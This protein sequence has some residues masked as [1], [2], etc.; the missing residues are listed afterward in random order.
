[1]VIALTH[2]CRTWRE[3]FTSRSSLWTEFHCVDSDK[4]RVYSE[5]SKSSPIT[6]WLDRD[7]GLLPQDPFLQIAPD[8]ISRLKSLFVS[9]TPDHLQA[10][11]NYFSR[12]A[13]LLENLEIFGSSDDPFL[14]PVL[15]TTLFDGDLSSLR[16][17]CLYSLHTT[18]PWRN[19]VNLT[20][21]ELG[22]VM[23]PRVTVGQLLDFFESAPSLVD[24]DLTFSTP[25]LGA[26]SGRLVPLAHLRKLSFNGFQPSSL[27]LEHLLIP[28]GVKMT[29]DLDL[30]GP[31]IE[32]Y[33]PRS[34]DNLRNL[35]NFKRIR[36]HFGFHFT[37]ME[38]IGPNGLV[39][40]DSMSPGADTPR[41][42][43]RSL[44]TLDTS[45]T[46]RLEIL[47]SE[48]L[49]EDLH[50]VL[51]S[52]KNLR[53]V[54]LSLCKDLRSFILA[55]APVPNSTTQIACPRLEELVFR[56]EERFDVETMVEVAAARA[57][58]GSPLKSIRIINWGELVSREEVTELLKHISH[59]E[60]SFEA[61]NVNYGYGKRSD[62]A[63][64]HGDD[65]DEEG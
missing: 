45:K 1:M 35:S 49:S 18:L 27:L 36:V 7:D 40:I 13:P 8:S 4:T 17:L 11:T 56:T 43:A 37:S 55:L 6:L 5:R 16:G 28:A 10:I 58:G 12:P 60:T 9:T 31:R 21:F 30:D 50:Q 57:S 53:T 2:V 65:S 14:N 39:E 46:K 38:F 61:R 52:M 34:L 24:V 25:A 41:S 54:T 26:Q 44:A 48:P 20:S 62:E 23:Y 29:I 22:Y 32:D 33:L 3:M 42:V 63:Y 59:V 15:T 64:D 51:V 47:R 19:M